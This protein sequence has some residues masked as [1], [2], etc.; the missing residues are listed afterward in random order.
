MQAVATE[1]VVNLESIKMAFANKIGSAG[2]TAWIAPLKYELCDGC[3]NLVAHNQFAADYVRNV[4]GNTLSN[5][6]ADFS[7]K[8]NISVA[9]NNNVTPT[10]N[11]NVVCEFTPNKQPAKKTV[12]NAF[13]NFIVSDENMFAVAACKKMALGDASFSQLFIYGP[14]GCGKTLLAKSICAHPRLPSGR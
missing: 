6:A 1:Q 3:L 2:F 10:A 8:L 7:L 11:D 5:I 12:K 4:Y 14:S 13:D 9:T